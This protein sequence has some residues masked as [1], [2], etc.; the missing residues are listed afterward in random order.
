MRFRVTTVLLVL[1]ALGIL[2]NPFVATT[3]HAQS[4]SLLM[5]LLSLVP[6]NPLVRDSELSYVDYEALIAARPGAIWPKSYKEWAALKNKPE[7]R[8]AWVALMGVSAGLSE[9]H[10][11]FAR[12]ENMVNSIGIDPFTVQRQIFFGK[13]PHTAVILQGK[14]DTAAIEKALTAK[15]YTPSEG[16]KSLWCAESCETG[17]KVDPKKI[18]RGNPFGGHLGQ[19]RPIAF[20]QEYVISSADNALV[21][22]I[23]AVQNQ[24]QPSLLASVDF[25]AA[26]ES[27]TAQGTV[28]QAYFVN[29]IYTSA[30]LSGARLTDQQKELATKMAGARVPIAAYSL[31]VVAHLVEKDSQFATIGLVY[32]KATD[33]QTAGKVILERLAQSQ[34]L[35]VRRPFMELITERSG[36]LDP[37]EVYTS[38]T[39]KSVLMLAIRA[40]LESQTP[41]NDG[42]YVNSGLLYRLLINALVS[43]DTD[44]LAIG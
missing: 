28:L 18:D 11:Q 8:L 37:V 1:L 42:R 29:P 5:Q 35:R 20:T 34:S 27:I 15:G 4:D 25:H 26:A 3:Y 7:G 38:Q 17:T 44:W 22:S 16:N 23:L 30:S 2:V 36:K 19:R 31:V 14:F 41:D 32:N 12:P 21:E 33:A 40:P 10:Q 39:G 13:P 24:Q 6:D 9:V 43:R